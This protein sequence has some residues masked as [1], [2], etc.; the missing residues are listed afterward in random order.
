MKRVSAQCMLFW[1][2]LFK[3][4][5]AHGLFP[6]RLLLA[7]SSYLSPPV[8]KY[9]TCNFDDLEPAQFKVIQDQR[10]WCQSKAHWWF[11][12]LPPFCP[13]LYLSPLLDYFK[14]FLYYG[15]LISWMSPWTATSVHPKNFGGRPSVR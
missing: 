1:I 5:I 7:P 12:I 13:T 3:R 15:L 6:I 9:L 11:P 10:S 8:L 4:S 2:S 14:V